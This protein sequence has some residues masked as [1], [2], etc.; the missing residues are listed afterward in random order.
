MYLFDTTGLSETTLEAE[1]LQVELYRAK[2]ASGRYKIIFLG[3]KNIIT[4]LALFLVFRKKL[5]S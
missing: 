2:S 3:D 4:K 1:A 5:T